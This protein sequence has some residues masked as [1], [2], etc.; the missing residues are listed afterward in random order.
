M[1]SLHIQEYAD[2]ARTGSG[3]VLPGGLEPALASQAV[4]FTTTTASAAFNANTKF[5]RIV[6][7]A[8]SYLVFAAAPTSAVTDMLLPAD[9]VGFF[10]VKPGQKVSAYD[11][12]S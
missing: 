12:S 3:E 7:A 6:C 4:T 11:G 9:T 2:I 10:A 1:A 8:D 5:V